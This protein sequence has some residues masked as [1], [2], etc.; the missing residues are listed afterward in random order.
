MSLDDASPCSATSRPGVPPLAL[1]GER[2]LPDVPEENYWFRRHLAV[3]EWIAE[4]VAGLRVADLACGEGYG[5]DLLAASAAEVVGVDANPEAHEHAR[6]RYRRSNLR[7][8]RDLVESYRGP[9]DAIVFLQTIEHVGDPGR[10]ARRLRPG[11]A[12]E[13]TSRR[14][15]GSRSPRRAPRSPTTHGTCA[16]TRRPST[17]RCSRPN[18]PGSSSTGSFT[19]A[20]CAS[21]ELALR[22]RLGPT[23]TR[24]CGSPSRST[25]ASSPRSPPRTSL[26]PEAD[27]DLDRALDFVAV[28]RCVTRGTRLGRRRPGDRPPLAHALRRGV[29]HLSVR[30]GMAVR[31]GDPL[32]PAGLRGR[33]AADDDGHPGARRPARGRRGGRAPASASCAGSGSALRGRRDRR[34]AAAAPG[35]PGRG[36]SAT[37]TRS[38]GSRRSTANLLALFGDPAAGGRIELLASAATHAVLPLV[39]TL[40]GRRLQVDAGLRSHRRRFGEPSGFWLPECAYEPGLEQ[41]LAER[42]LAC[43]CVDQSAHEPG[44]RGAGSCGDRRRADRVHDRLGGGLVALVAGRLS[45]RSA[46]T[47]TSTAGRCAARARGRSTAGRTTLSAAAARAREQA[48]E[49]VATV[50]ARLER[51]VDRARP[52]RPGRVRDRHRAARPL[53]VGGAGM[54]PRGDQRSPMRTESSWSAS[55]RRVGAIRARTARCG[56][57]PGARARTCGPGTRPRSPT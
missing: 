4:R 35:L 41:L 46:T 1:T 33:R 12:G 22:G 49:F 10:A 52:P 8:E 27:R 40:A 14:R 57:R 6:L 5:A 47:P 28:C 50:A 9:C 20:S 38:S 25:T 56:A 42:D 7:F 44:A 11:G 31:R 15:T 19:P 45:L 43:F 26:R 21:H 30:R 48:R 23:S 34:R 55:A 36:A 51:Y 39:A 53:V 17:G 29:R 2:T 3:Y 13:L 37:A 18:S 16:S 54:A 24:R 32:L